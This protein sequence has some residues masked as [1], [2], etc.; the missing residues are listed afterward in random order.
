MKNVGFAAVKA[1]Q[2]ECEDV[3]YATIEMLNALLHVY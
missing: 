3:S 1:L 2:R